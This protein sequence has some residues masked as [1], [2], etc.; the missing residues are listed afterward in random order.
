MFSIF[1]KKV[2][3]SFLADYQKTLAVVESCKT[4]E[5]VEVADNLVWNFYKKHI[6]TELRNIF[7][8]YNDL[9]GRVLKK[10]YLTRTQSARHKT[11]ENW[12]KGN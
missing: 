5:Q 12:K 7:P 8:Y 10:K 4:Y 9:K 1:K 11:Q 3:G 2:D 6:H